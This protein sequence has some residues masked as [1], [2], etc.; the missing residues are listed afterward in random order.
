M[1]QPRPLFHLFSSFQTHI[2]NFTT[3]RY[4]KKVHPVYLR[5]WDSNSRPWEHESPPITTRPGLPPNRRAFFVSKV[6]LLNFLSLYVVNPFLL[7]TT[8]FS[9]LWSRISS[10]MDR[11]HTLGI[12]KVSFL[13][14][15]KKAFIKMLRYLF[16][17]WIAVL[18]KALCFKG[19]L[20][21]VESMLQNFF[22]SKS[23]FSKNNEIEWKFLLMPK[24]TQ[25]LEKQCYF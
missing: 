5:C 2:T 14:L 9:L 4:G 16:G 7:T 10:I 21:R 19:K 17:G 3:N 1:G 23:R 15:T 11:L 22:W 6:K 18:P 12:K 25:N 20:H 8:L 13:R 24:P